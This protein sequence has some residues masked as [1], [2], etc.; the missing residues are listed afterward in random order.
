MEST[1]GFKGGAQL[2]VLRFCS[3]NP[4]KIHELNIIEAEKSSLPGGR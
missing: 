1:T 4:N 2:R 3:E